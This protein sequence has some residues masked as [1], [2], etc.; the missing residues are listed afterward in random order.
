MFSLF[1]CLFDLFVVV[2]GF[3]CAFLIANE[4]VHRVKPL[5]PA[6]AV[7]TLINDGNPFPKPVDRRSNMVGSLLGLIGDVKDFVSI[8]GSILKR[9]AVVVPIIA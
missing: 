1:D 9:P 3:L 8:Q 4:G 2:V 5:Q 7:I 6:G